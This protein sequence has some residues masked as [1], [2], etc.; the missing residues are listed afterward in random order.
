[1]H[2]VIQ[3]DLYLSSYK[4]LSKSKYLNGLQCSKLLWVAVNDFTR[5]PQV[6]ETTQSVF[7]QGHFVGELAQTLYPGG[8]NVYNSSISDNLRETKAALVLRKPLF[9]AGFSASRLFCRVDILNPVG[10]EAWDIIEVKSSTE[11]R[12]E[13]LHDV[14]FQRHCCHLAG[15]PVQRCRIVYLNKDFIKNGDVDPAQLFNIEDVTDRLGEFSS[16]IDERI[17]QMLA[18]ISSSESPEAAVG[19]H[20]NSPYSCALQEECWAY[21]PE[22]HVMTLYYG[23]KLGEELLGKGIL[24]IADIPIDV[25]LNPL[26]QIQRE[27]VVCGQPHI[28]RSEIRA[29]I[30]SLKYPLYFMDFE[31]FMAAIPMYDGSR[32]YQSIPFQFSV[33]SVE[34]PG[35]R[36]KHYAFLADG[37][38]DPRSGFL[39]AL[40]K[41][42][43]P[44]GSILVYY[45]AFERSRLKELAQAFPEYKS[46]VE[47]I[48]NRII[49]LLKPFKSFSYYHPSQ[50]GSASLK[51][52]MPAVTGI[53]Y[54]AL[55][56]S[57]GDIASLRYMQAT[58]GQ[59]S[60][61]DRNKIRKDLLQYCEQDTGGM[62]RIV[63]KLVLESHR[64]L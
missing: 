26:Q 11:I 31:T 54:D 41:S 28:N 22:H 27:C 15:L 38:D 19:Q 5:L 29:F 2:N 4:S 10:D 42:I 37:K 57:H 13:H 25:K 64:L 8:L 17:A 51:K 23:K 63:E 32:P 34:Q 62:V 20:C 59:V 24:H 36:A 35:A 52:V 39:A 48:S 55:E 60:A 30:E 9:E 12:A 50:M 14:A 21:L 43:G 18:L 47:G 61:E 46:W 40:K 6:N 7:D 3:E 33:H 1:V 45:E 49:D 53:G 56:I 44:D 16:G 58:F